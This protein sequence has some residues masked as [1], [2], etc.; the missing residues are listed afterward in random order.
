VS[1]IERWF[2]DRAARTTTLEIDDAQ[3]IDA[4]CHVGISKCGLTLLLHY[5]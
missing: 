3:K 2:R 4:T 5:F 1:Y